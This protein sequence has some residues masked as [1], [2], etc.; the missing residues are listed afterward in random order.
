MKMK[1]I[2][3]GDTEAR[4]E[5][6]KACLCVSV[7]NSFYRLAL[8]LLLCFGAGAARGQQPAPAGQARGHYDKG[9]ELLGARQGDAAI[10][11]VGE[12]VRLDPDNPEAHSYLGYAF[13][14]KGQLQESAKEFE[15]AVRLKPDFSEGYYYLGTARW[16]SGDTQGAVAALKTAARL[17][18]GHADAHYYLGLA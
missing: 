13:G 11:E 16:F 8:A 7:V 15:A 17:M 1:T 12:A 18:P 14:V 9:V 10:A 3:H 6:L 5:A 4:L 2:H